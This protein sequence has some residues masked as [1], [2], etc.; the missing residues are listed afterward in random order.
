M[1]LDLGPAGTDRRDVLAEVRKIR[2]NLPVVLTSGSPE[3]T[4]LPYGP[5]LQFLQKPFRPVDLKGCVRR[6]IGSTPRPGPL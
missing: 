6:V 4:G 3:P 5:A 1:L 2:P